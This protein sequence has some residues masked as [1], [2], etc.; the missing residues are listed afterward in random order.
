VHSQVGARQIIWYD[1]DNGVRDAGHLG[2]RRVI[3]LRVPGK[4]KYRDLAVRVIA[5]AC[6]LVGIDDEA[7]SGLNRLSRDFDD[8]VVSAFGEA[9]NN[10]AIHG[11]R[12]R[13]VGEVEIEIETMLD[14]IEIRIADQGASFDFGRVPA[15]NLEALPEAGLGIYII[16]AFVDEVTYQ[17]GSPNVLK[18]TK[19]LNPNSRL[20]GK[21]GLSTL[22][23]RDEEKQ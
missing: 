2:G 13:S 16:K 11:Y 8:Q 23:D 22:F 12:G 5:A 17:P 1:P 18:M 15:P 4:L 21:P 9:F 6:K 20:S 3:R 14:R 19:Y 7:N 10:I